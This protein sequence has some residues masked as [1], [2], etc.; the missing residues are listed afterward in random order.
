[1]KSIIQTKVRTMTYYL[2]ELRLDKIVFDSD[3]KSDGILTDLEKITLHKSEQL[4][5]SKV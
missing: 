4:Q 3:R 2:T 5:K 1:M